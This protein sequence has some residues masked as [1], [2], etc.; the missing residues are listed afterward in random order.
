MT[1]G[2]GERFHIAIFGKTN[3]GKSSLFNALL[4][5]GVSVVSSISGTTTD[6]V[7]KNFELLDAGP[8]VFI[9]TAGFGDGTELAEAREKAA[10][11]IIPKT[12]YALVTL[13]ALE[14]DYESFKE[15]A[16]ELRRFRIPMLMVLTKCDQL[17]PLQKEDLQAQ[18]PDAFLLSSF[19]QEDI[20]KLL[21]HLTEQV[22]LHQTER[23]LVADL[24]PYGARI[25]LVVPIDSE[26]PKGRIINPQVQV[27]REALDSG[28]EVT[29]VRDT[30]L[31]QC[32]KRLNYEVDL[33]VTDSQAFDKVSKIVPSHI[34]L[35]GFSILFIRYKGD[36]ES[37][38][39]GLKVL[40][41]IQPE[42]KIAVAESCSHNISCE[43]IGRFKIPNLLKKLL[44]FEPKIDF[45]TG[46]D[47]PEKPKDYKILIHCGACMTN[48]Q[49]VLSRIALSKDASTALINYGVLL[50][51]G[52]DI[53]ER[54]LK[55]FYDKGIIR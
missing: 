7:H 3:S 17:S 31:E 53:L 33:V 13:D 49:T 6:A 47:F 24:L 26:A 22:K 41:N 36:L 15:T 10:R 29:V 39:S 51:Y 48:R 34:Y 35:T 1:T 18:Y 42:D 20:E 14:L 2:R 40:K 21:A 55:I 43:D 32:L 44:G 30:E 45:Y 50:A 8:V 38:V 27:I 4:G 5:Q 28:F 54:S 19:S 52:A 25:V 9:D 16:R 12:D 46:S 23:C 11:N 37:F